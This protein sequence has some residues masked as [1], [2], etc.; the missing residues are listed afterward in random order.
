MNFE[1][2]QKYCFYGK[3]EAI[4]N[5][6]YD[7]YA[8]NVIGE[9]GENLVVRLDQD[10]KVSLNKIYHFETEAIAFKDK[11]H[12]LANKAV[13]IGEMD[14]EDDEKERLL[15]KFYHYA[16]IN[17]AKV[18]KGIEAKLEAIENQIVKDIAKI[19]YDKY[20][21]DFYMFP[22]AT[23]FHHAYISGLAYHTYS[24]LK[25]ADGFL[26][27]YPFLS[28]DLVY[29]GVILHDIGKI[30][31]FDTYE[32]SEYTIKGRLIGHITMGANLIDQAARELGYEES[33]EAM[34]LSHIMISH[35]YYGNFGSPKKPNTA[36]ALII[37]FL[38]NID[39]K[40]C[41]L[42][43]ELELIETGNLTSPIGVLDRERYYKHK[44]S[45]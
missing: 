27:V 39:S 3:V 19:V 31:E 2:G 28:S 35:H 8:I 38:D 24:M 15:R 20:Q 37:H 33:E 21:D 22:A 16:P 34:L 6:T 44:L 13:I 9:E 4:N 32:G 41:V 7:T 25:L 18:R 12:L 11:I 14:L 26:Q 1:I 10:F 36:E 23:K 43:E 40:V 5:S 30:L 42:G 45:K 29:A 17:L